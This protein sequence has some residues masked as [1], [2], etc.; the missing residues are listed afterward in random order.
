M[1]D[2]AGH[3]QSSFSRW[4]FI[5]GSYDSCF[6][7][8]NRVYSYTLYI[9]IHCLVMLELF[10]YNS[11]LM[12]KFSVRCT[13]SVIK[14]WRNWEFQH[15]AKCLTLTGR[16]A[17]SYDFISYGSRAPQGPGSGDCQ[18][19]HADAIVSGVFGTSQRRRIFTKTGY[20][21]TEIAKGKPKWSFYQERSHI[22][23]TNSPICGPVPNLRRTGE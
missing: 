2:T 4:K 8:C 3:L 22:E 21:A 20:L 9:T 7:T 11:V 13:A 16:R 14:R 18:H 6:M 19:L 1:H 17:R 5:F 23:A 12:V 15:R 10:M